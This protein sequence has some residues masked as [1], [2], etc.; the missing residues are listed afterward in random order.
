[1]HSSSIHSS[2]TVV[3]AL[4]LILPLGTSGVPYED[5]AMEFHAIQDRIFPIIKVLDPDSLNR[6][7]QGTNISASEMPMHT[8]IGGDLLCVYGVDKGEYFELLQQGQLPKDVTPQFVDSISQSNLFHELNGKIQLHPTAF[9]GY[10]FTCGGEHEAALITLPWTWSI[11]EKQVGTE[12]VFGVPSK[13]LLVFVDANDSAAIAGLRAL[14]SEIHLGGDRLLSERLF[15]Y[16][17]GRIG[18]YQAP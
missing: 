16:S 9:G 11:A 7:R 17:N 10:V 8:S 3:L 1:M 6:G 14:I 2:S 13:D 5:T 12:I 15:T 18:A 4:A